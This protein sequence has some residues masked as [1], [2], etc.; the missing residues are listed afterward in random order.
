M[1]LNE[2]KI[3]ALIL[4]NGPMSKRMIQQKARLSWSTVVKMVT[5][6]QENGLIHEKGTE[7]KRNVQGK[8]AI[9]YDLSSEYPLILSID[10]EY[11]KTQILLTNLKKE[12][13]ASS[14]SKTPKLSD[15]KYI[16][17]YLED[18]IHE[19]LEVNRMSHESLDGIGISI[20]LFIIKKSNGNFYK[21]LEKELCRRLNVLVKTSSPSQAYT[22]Y[23]LQK[24]FK[25]KNSLVLVNRGGLGGGIILDGK[26]YSGENR[27]AGEIG[28]IILP[29]NT[30]TCQCGKTG[31]IETILNKKEIYNRYQNEINNVTDYDEPTIAEYVLAVDRLIQLWE[32]GDNKANNIVNDIIR[33]LAY[34]IY[35]MITIVDIKDI[36]IAGYFGDS[37][38]KLLPS[39]KNEILQRLFINKDINIYYDKFDEEGFLKVGPAHRV[40]EEYLEI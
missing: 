29:N 40:F 1:T 31:C 17:E 23:Q 6:L 18:A 19:F 24:V 34:V 27:L 12:T 38:K 36:Y 2:K 7:V 37:G 11:S 35:I 28:H 20:P 22:Y 16:C 3:L 5:R 10:V 33:V 39:I 8:D 9:L 21:E 26:L 4:K 32:Q 13:I 25:R 14:I 30:K 15:L